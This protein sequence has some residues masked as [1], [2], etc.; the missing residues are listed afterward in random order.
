MRSFEGC[1]KAGKENWSCIEL[2]N[3]S[4]SSITSYNNV[5]TFNLR[6]LVEHVFLKETSVE[7]VKG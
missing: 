6:E 7:M 4:V 2:A 3:S 5:L 1:E